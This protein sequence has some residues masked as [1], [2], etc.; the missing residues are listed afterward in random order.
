VVRRRRSRT[1]RCRGPTTRPAIRAT[2]KATVSR[3]NRNL[4]AGAAQTTCDLGLARPGGTLAFLLAR[5][6]LHLTR[7]RLAPRFRRFHP[8]EV[9]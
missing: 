2:T 6:R 9:A 3:R 7:A 8:P 4:A 5:L 1:G